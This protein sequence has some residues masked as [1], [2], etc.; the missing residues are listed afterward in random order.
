MHPLR[1]GAPSRAPTGTVTPTEPRPVGSALLSSLI[2]PI[3][4]NIVRAGNW[5]Q[6][7]GDDASR[8]MKQFVWMVGDK[9]CLEYSQLDLAK[10]RNA[11]RAMLNT[12]RVQS[13]WHLPYDEAIKQFPKLTDVN[14]RANKTLNK[15][16]S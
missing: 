5:T 1:K 15:Y 2:A 10:F 7:V 4:A 6:G 9:P 3:I 13:I 16:L 12:V 14:K 11:L 8:L